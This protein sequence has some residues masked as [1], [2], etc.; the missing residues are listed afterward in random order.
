M[1]FFTAEIAAQRGLVSAENVMYSA[2]CD[3]AGAGEV[4]HLL[5]L[6]SQGFLSSSFLL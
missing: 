5:K 2:H 6:C 3:A 4:T 1:N